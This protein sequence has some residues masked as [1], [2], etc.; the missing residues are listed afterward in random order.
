M[1]AH[2][3]LMVGGSDRQHTHVRE[4]ESKTQGEKGGTSIMLAHCCAEWPSV[5][6]VF[7]SA[8]SDDSDR[9]D[10]EG[11]ER[12]RNE[13]D[14]RGKKGKRGRERGESREREG[15]RERE[16]NNDEEEGKK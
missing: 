4:R 14:R 5:S 16:N 6:N 9:Y 7:M 10:D 3:I 15:E 11:G 1:D 13:R 2:M 8:P 12:G